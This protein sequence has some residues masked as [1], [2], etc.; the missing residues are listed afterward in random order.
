M[1]H[2]EP[3]PAF[4]DNYIWIIFDE[5]KNACVIDPGDARPVINFLDKLNLNLK[6]ILITHHHLD[7]VGGVTDLKQKYKLKVYG[8]N[9]PKIKGID[10]FLCESNNGNIKLEG[11]DIEFKV[12]NIPGHTLDHIAYYSDN[13]CDNPILFCGDTLF[14]GG[15]GRVFEGTYKQM[16]DSLNKLSSL[17]NDTIIYCAHEYT[18]NNL[19]F[20]KSIL[21]NKIKSYYMINS[22]IKKVEKL[23]KD[24]LPSLPSSMKQE[25]L[26]NLFIRLNDKNLQKMLNTEGDELKTF[27]RL[28]TLKDSFTS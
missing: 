17:P 22:Y 12:I 16:M 23:R 26:I 24:G 9:N 6:T 11:L 7:H 28:R 15:C 2:I 10:Q 21:S 1:L 14:S 19:Y 13:N 4:N 20:A 27:T 18:L 8:P 5:N 25:K 3:I